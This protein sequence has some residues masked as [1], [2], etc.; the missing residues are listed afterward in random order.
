MKSVQHPNARVTPASSLR[1]PSVFGFSLSLL[2]LL[3]LAGVM[4]A[5]SPGSTGSAFVAGNRDL[6]S[7]DFSKV[8]VGPA[9]ASIQ[10]IAGTLDV[11]EKDGVHMLRGSSPATFLVLIPEKIP[12]HFTLEFDLVPRRTGDTGGTE[13]SFEGTRQP[14]RS[15]SSAQVMWNHH[16]ATVIG[17]GTNYAQTNKSFPDDL[18]EEIIGNRTEV[19]AAFDGDNLRLFTNGQQIYDLK[20]VK[21]VRGRVL[22]IELGGTDSGDNAVY[23]ARFRIAAS[24][25]T[26]A[27]AQNKSGLTSTSSQPITPQPA[28]SGTPSNL[29]TDSSTDTHTAS[30]VSTS[31]L[32]ITGI[33][34][35]VNSAGVATVTWD[36][37]TISATYQVLRWVVGDPTCCNNMSPPGAQLQSASW[38]DG[39][40]AA[41]FTY[42]YRVIATTAGGLIAGETRFTYSS[43]ATPPP[44]VAT[45][46]TTPTLSDR[47]IA[48]APVTTTSSTYMTSGR[49]AAISPP[50]GG[51]SGDTSVS[52]IGSLPTSTE[53]VASVT[54]VPAVQTGTLTPTI[55]TSDT[56]A[57]VEALPAV[58]TGTITPMTVATTDP[59]LA[60][61]T[62]SDNSG[63]GAP[64][65]TTGRYRVE[66]AGFS[67]A[68]ATN[69]DPLAADGK[70]DEIYAAA[71]VVNWNRKLK[72]LTTFTT[73]QTLDHGDVGTTHLFGDR[74][75]AGSASMSGGILASD[76]VPGSFDP[77]GA[78]LPAPTSD[79][80]PL[81]VWEGTLTAATETLVV[82]PSLWE[83]DLVRAQFSSY[84]DNWSKASAA[85]LMISPVVANQLIGTTLT[86]AVA[87]ISTMVILAPPAPTFTGSP[88]DGYKIA[89]LT[90]APETDRPV[91]LGSGG[92]AVVTYQDRFIVV[93]QER[94]A[95][96]GVGEGITLPMPYGE[97]VG[98]LTGA[99][100]TLY[101]RV[102]RVQ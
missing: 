26:L 31:P 38:Q 37:L 63:G 15:D 101:V 85:A 74:I 17:G 57:T 41:G 83:H 18:R 80:F 39:V 23:L 8:P 72:Q 29:M 73:A 89:E 14:T 66:I 24:G 10:P 52:T 87:P 77:K 90:F 98:T 20:G 35:T 76:S 100:Y 13:L 33:K 6:V 93:T 59:S 99:I 91:G 51:T 48:T 96:L 79:R 65:T 70:G 42:G 28:D 62:S 25:G 49:L 3:P 84:K 86:S 11:V 45:T 81:L 69:D 9:P 60:Q 27:T 71:V 46:S 12:E 44:G 78:A 7:L 36:P 92:P 32:A 53:P 5:Q 22:R 56:V 68:R 34:V 75:Q 88:T 97:P 50:P 40:L 102:Q 16:D 61:P 82:S 55:T 64:A 2:F 58:Q 47:T 94:V 1:H 4:R 67:V 21:F 30:T 95:A 19:R 54:A 43:A